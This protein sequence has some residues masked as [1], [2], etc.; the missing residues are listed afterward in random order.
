[1]F[2]NLSESKSS[3]YTGPTLLKTR[4]HTQWEH[5]LQRISHKANSFKQDY[6]NTNE[7]ACQHFFEKFLKNFLEGKSVRKYQKAAKPQMEAAAF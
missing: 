4:V 3:L 5:F 2:E 1:M 6:N 7:I